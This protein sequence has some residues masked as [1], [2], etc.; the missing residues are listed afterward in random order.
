MAPPR[1]YAL[2]DLD[3][4]LIPQDTLLLLCNYTL[5]RHRARMLYLLVFLPVVPLAAL[6][7]IGSRT[8]KRIFLCFLHGLRRPYIEA[9]ALDFCKRSVIPRIYPELRAEIE[10]H[11]KDGRIT[12][13]NTASP[14][15]YAR[16]IAAELGFDHVRATPVVVPEVLPWFPKIDGPNNKRYAKI[17]R[18]M[19]LLPS[20][21][22]ITLGA[23][24]PADPAR[25]AYPT[26]AILENS[27]AYSD[28]PADLPLLR[29]TEHAVLIHPE[30]ASLI[31]EG[32]LKGWTVMQPLRPYR[33][34]VGKM[35]HALR[36]ILG[37]YPD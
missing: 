9:V 7:I 1:G 34:V 14:E 35:W 2:F 30:K 16:H 20:A 18:M 37:A 6:G 28:S 23:A 36:Q 32:A 27:W 19:E 8:L 21:V 5:K 15:F 31:E 26:E 25:P 22:Q 33:S 11:K 17:E 10:R 13:L 4:T 29:L 24:P 12:I 3:Y